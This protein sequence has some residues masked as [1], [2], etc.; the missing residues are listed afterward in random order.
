MRR[1]EWTYRIQYVRISLGCIQASDSRQ[2]NQPRLQQI[3][4]CS[5]FYK[6]EIWRERD[7]E[8]EIEKERNRERERER[9]REIER[10]RDRER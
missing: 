1:F 4:T 10:E 6:I 9:D 3:P 5:Q 8:R 2:F 7:I